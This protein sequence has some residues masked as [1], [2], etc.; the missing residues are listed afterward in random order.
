MWIVKDMEIAR[1]RMKY[2]SI[3]IVCCFGF[4]TMDTKGFSVLASKSGVLSQRT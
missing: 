4:K 1:Q 3:D 2:T